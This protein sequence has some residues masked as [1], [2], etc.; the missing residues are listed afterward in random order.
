MEKK[1]LSFIMESRKNEVKIVFITT[2]RGMS[3]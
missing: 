2:M 1:I 3:L